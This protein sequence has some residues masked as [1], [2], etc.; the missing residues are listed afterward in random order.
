[1]TAMQGQ[2][3]EAIGKVQQQQNTLSSTEDFIKQV[4][5]SHQTRFFGVD[6]KLSE[7]DVVA[8]QNKLEII[9][10][11]KQ[12]DGNTVVYLLLPQAPVEETIQIQYQIYVQPR[13]SFLHVKN[14]LIFFWGQTPLGLNTAPLAV[15]YFPDTSDTDIAH[16]LSYHDGRVFAD[17]QPLPKIGELNPDFKGNKWIKVTRQP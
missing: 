9:V 17:D 2:L 12:K 8:L 15:S 4:F 10:P 14:I 7:T 5:S 13:N 16:A 3:S 11:P 6:T 1:M